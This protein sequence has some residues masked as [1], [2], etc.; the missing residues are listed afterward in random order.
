MSPTTYMVHQKM[1][2]YRLIDE[3][4]TNPVNNRQE[5]SIHI[6]SETLFAIGGESL[7]LGLLRASR[8]VL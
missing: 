6:A 3:M 4:K 8:K 2:H 7:W 1:E 5:R